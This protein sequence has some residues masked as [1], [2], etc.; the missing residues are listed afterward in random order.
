MHSRLLVS[1]VLIGLGLAAFGQTDFRP[2]YYI[3]SQLDTVFGQIDYR[4]DLRNSKH[5]VYK[6]GEGAEEQSFGPGE[7]YGYRFEE[8][9]FYVSKAIGSAEGT[10]TVFL[11]YLVDGITDLYYYRDAQKDHYFLETE[12]GELKELKNEESVLE[13]D[14]QKYVWKSNEHIATLKSTFADC[15]EIQPRL[16]HAEL[17]HKSLINL[18]SSYHDYVCDDGKCIIYQKKVPVVRVNPGLVLGYGSSGLDFVIYEGYEDLV[19][20]RSLD[21]YVGIQLRLNS[22][23]IS[24]RI[25]ILLQSEWT[26][27]YYHSYTQEAVSTTTYHRDYHIRQNSI[28][29]MIGLQYSF[30]L[31][32]FSPGLAVGPV[33]DYRLLNEFRLIQEA[34]SP[35]MVHT[36]EYTDGPLMK[37]DT[38][39]AFFQAGTQVQ[40]TDRQYLSFNLR[41][42]YTAETFGTK[43][44]YNSLSLNMGYFF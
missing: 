3:T 19:F 25:F 44:V 43:I 29:T 24:E 42:H 33:F 27:V 1:S 10:E 17:T 28:R 8:G 22:P 41:Y 34:E 7:I 4:G 15:M 5:C 39:G 31:G 18:T 9:K 23:R 6:A 30:P 2:G 12:D 37:D 13:V 35:A 40:V 21:P 20:E 16:D 32:R 11:E 38:M 26:K 36:S 14:G